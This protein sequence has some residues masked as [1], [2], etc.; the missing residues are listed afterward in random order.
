MSVRSSSIGTCGVV[1]GVVWIYYMNHRYYIGWNIV[2]MHEHIQQELL[3]AHK[4]CKYY[5][6]TFVSCTFTCNT[7]SVKYILVL[8]LREIAT[9]WLLQWGGGLITDIAA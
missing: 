7:H 4:L 5:I 6:T 2:S 1:T 3:L 8:L 9:D